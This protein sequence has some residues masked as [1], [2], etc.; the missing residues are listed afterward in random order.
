[1]L[2]VQKFPWTNIEGQPPMT[3]APRL[4]PLLNQLST[5]EVATARCTFDV[6]PRLWLTANLA[7]SLFAREEVSIGMTIQVIC[8]PQDMRAFLDLLVAELPAEFTA[9]VRAECVEV[10]Q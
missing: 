5:E 6:C 7:G 1:M 2:T 10:W 8:K 9:A 4:T 3:F